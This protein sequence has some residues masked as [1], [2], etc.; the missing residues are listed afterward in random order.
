M[1][2]KKQKKKVTPAS[3][4]TTAQVQKQRIARAK[5]AKVTAEKNMEA[6]AGRYERLKSLNS[7]KQ[8][9]AKTALSKTVKTYEEKSK[10]YRTTVGRRG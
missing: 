6:A 4:R 7:P 2:K 9:R 8:V 1:V 10:A 3:K 5:R